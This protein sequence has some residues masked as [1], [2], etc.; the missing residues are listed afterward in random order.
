MNTATEN[1]RSFVAA[2]DDETM[3]QMEERAQDQGQQRRCALLTMAR[4]SDT[5]L[6]LAAEDFETFEQVA[7]MVEDFKD[8]AASQ[9]EIAQEA[10]DRISIVRGTRQALSH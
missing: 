10:A 2:I 9:A 4:D 7:A 8:F 3:E 6:K 5:L 1:P